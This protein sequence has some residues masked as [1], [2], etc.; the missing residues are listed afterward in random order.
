MKKKKL[1]PAQEAWLLFQ[2]QPKPT[3]IDELKN[4]FV[5]SLIVI[6]FIGGLISGY[7]FAY[8][9]IYNH[10]CEIIGGYWIKG[11]C[12]NKLAMIPIP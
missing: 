8:E 9:S 4:F 11:H 1:S 10:Q 5:P 2:S 7:R 12:V 3:M 6:A